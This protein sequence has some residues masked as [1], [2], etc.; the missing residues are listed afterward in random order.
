MAN[1]SPRIHFLCSTALLAPV[2]TLATR[3]E[4]MT[5][6]GVSTT[7][8]PSGRIAQQF[9]DG[10]AADAIVVTKG[11]IANLAACGR[12]LGPPHAA[13]AGS[14]LGLA[15]QRGQ[16]RPDLATAEEFADALLG[17]ERIA[18]SDPS[19]GALSGADL[20]GMFKRLGIA[21]TIREKCIYG[22]G[23]SEGLTAWYL[24]R[25]EA[26]IALQQLSELLAVPGIDVVGPLPEAVQLFT[27]FYGAVPSH[28]NNA[29]AAQQWLDVLQT[30]D[31]CD[32]LKDNGLVPLA[33]NG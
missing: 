4:R 23:G 17:A 7:F 3:F 21:E 31:A 13:I 12:V 19:G 27:D 22:P 24:L 28:T 11:A 8:G 25:G 20:V 2:T 16:S 30:R 32:L 10:A 1:S 33:R 29:S 5:G 14:M 18:M 6:I 9:M 15:V 26:D